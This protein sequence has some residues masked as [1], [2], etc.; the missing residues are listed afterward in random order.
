MR[1]KYSIKSNGAYSSFTSFGA[2]TLTTI[3]CLMAFAFIMT[4][5]DFS[6]GMIS[7]FGSIAAC[8][9]SYFFSF[10][11]AKKRRKDGII[12][13]LVCG[14]ISFAALFVLNLLFIRTGFTQMLFSKL[15]MLLICS[16]IGG[17]IGVNAKIRL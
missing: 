10:L 14:M 12:V 4:K 9:G 7:S 17:I 16:I 15:S 6:D 13:G 3:V 2:G 5:I 11:V 1:K 8:V